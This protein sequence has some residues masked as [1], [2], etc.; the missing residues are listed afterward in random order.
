MGC[1]GDTDVS[2]IQLWKAADP[3]PKAKKTKITY[4]NGYPDTINEDGY[5][6]IRQLAENIKHL[7][8]V[9][10]EARKRCQ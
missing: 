3:K 1:N 6:F 2:E 7:R 9:Q 10:H 5:T 8:A 4:A